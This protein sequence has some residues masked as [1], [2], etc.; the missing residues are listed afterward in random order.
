MHRGIYTCRMRIL[1][2]NAPMHRKSVQSL[3]IVGFTSLIVASM[4]LAVYMTR[5]VPETVNRAGEAAVYFGSAFRTASAPGLN[6]GYT[7]PALYWIALVG[8]SLALAYLVLFGIVL[9]A[10]RRVRNVS[11]RVP[12]TPHM[13]EPSLPSGYSAYNGF[14][15]FV[16]RDSA[17]SVEDIVKGLSQKHR[18]TTTEHTADEHIAEP[19][20]NVEPIYEDVEPI[21]SDNIANTAKI[22]IQTRSFVIAL[23]EGD[24]TTVFSELRQHTRNGNTPEQFMSIALCLLDEVYRARIDGIDCDTDV[25][26]VAAR[27]PTPTLEKLIVSLATAIDSSYSSGATGAKLA[28]IRA[29]AVLG[30]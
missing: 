15:S 25:E 8:W 3:A 13:P 23:I 27:I 2:F 18:A 17:L 10:R 20:I 30:A 26:R 16:P 6:S 11:S 28:L 22:P 5:F 12:N 24:R 21:A 14:K 4:W 1:Q 7:G 29:L 19:T 9:L